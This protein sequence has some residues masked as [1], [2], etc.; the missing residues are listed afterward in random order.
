MNETNCRQKMFC[1]QAK[2]R[3]ATTSTLYSTR[4]LRM[5]INTCVPNMSL[6]RLILLDRR[7]RLKRVLYGN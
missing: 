1:V 3:A 7:L 5:S 4:T 2:L 6:H